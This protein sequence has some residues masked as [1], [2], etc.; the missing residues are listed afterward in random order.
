MTIPTPSPDTGDKT[1]KLLI[2]VL[3]LLVLVLVLAL[4][5][6][7]RIAGDRNGGS[8][9]DGGGQASSSEGG[10][11]QTPEERAVAAY[12][13]VL[14]NPE[15]LQTDLG[16]ETPSGVLRY[17]LVHLDDGNVPELLLNYGS[18]LV[19]PDMAAIVVY[20]VDDD[21]RKIQ[22][23]NA[24]YDGIGSNGA[25]VRVT[26]RA[27][28]QP[29]MFSAKSLLLEDVHEQMQ[30]TRQGNE[31][32]EQPAEPEVDEFE[33][34][35]WTPADDLGAIEAIADGDGAQGS[36]S[37]G[38]GAD[39][40]DGGP[41]PTPGQRA[42]G[43]RP[44]SGSS[45]EESRNAASG[46]QTVTGTVK[47][48]RNRAEVADYQ[49][50]PDPNPSTPDNRK[51]AILVLDEPT[52]VTAKVVGG[53]SETRTVEHV[54]INPDRHDD[55]EKVTITFSAD[56]TYWPSDTGIPFGLAVEDGAKG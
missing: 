28:R 16:E 32:V 4:F 35:T 30:V 51:F 22:F 13:E 53:G 39:G 11:A 29:G 1:R 42:P 20:G 2:A 24:Y 37:G 12:K 7:V 25:E 49:Q 31:L 55:G 3:V 45:S 27:T 46:E 44:G 36:D 43:E 33:Q 56:D 17:A 26:L 6:I 14:A 38:A 10:A 9:A 18:S 5:L 52:D 8:G 21:G 47:I 34:L 19:S 40:A 48:F 41:N 54:V 50:L 15:P 23:P